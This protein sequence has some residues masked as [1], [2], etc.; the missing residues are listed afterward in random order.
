MNYTNTYFRRRKPERKAIPALF[1][2]AG[3]PAFIP[4]DGVLSLRLSS[5]ACKQ[6]LML[7]CAVALKIP[8]SGQ[9]VLKA[10]NFDGFDGDEGPT[11]ATFNVTGIGTATGVTFVGPQALLRFPPVLLTMF[12]SRGILT[13]PP[14]P[15]HVRLQSTLKYPSAP[16]PASAYS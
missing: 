4:L 13:I 11:T 6:L 12:L 8:L 14:W 2:R 1:R 16:R 15:A 9:T 10:W 3:L 7:I 5:V